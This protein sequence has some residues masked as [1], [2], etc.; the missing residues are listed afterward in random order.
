MA[1]CSTCIP[2]M[3]TEAHVVVVGHE[4]DLLDVLDLVVELLGHAERRWS[5]FLPDSEIS[6]LNDHAGQAVQVHPSTLALV[7][8]AVEGW[9]LTGGAFD[10]TVL[11]DVVRAGYGTSLVGSLDLSSPVERAPGDTDLVRAC[12]DIRIDHDDSLVRLP[13]GTG[14][15]P[16]GIGK[17]LAADLA[18]AAALEA[19]ALGVCV[20]IGGDLRVE[21]IAPHGGT[22]TIAVERP[23]RAEPL[24]VLDVAGG[25]VATS[26]TTRRRWTVDGELR[27][28]VIDPRTG[29]P[30]DTDVD[31][32]TVVAGEAWRAE[33]LATGCL[34]RGADR[35]FDLLDVDAHALA[36][37]TAGD[38]RSSSGLSPYLRPRH[39]PA[40]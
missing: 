19:G 32:L 4:P 20:N 6:R 11:G 5:R 36:L 15:D 7:E 16:G 21:G 2:V 14:F 39:A 24:A 23:G 34:L 22:W 12:S 28:H 37:T 3:G 25:A 31:V 9:R 27:H 33:V 18:V 40:A 17:G 26:T 10:P 13:P 38:L 1:S 8:R 30:S 29:R 35:A